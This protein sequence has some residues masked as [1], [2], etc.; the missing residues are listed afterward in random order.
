MVASCRKVTPRFMHRDRWHAR[1]E[2][3]AGDF[4]SCSK[5][6]PGSG[7]VAST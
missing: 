4:G 5:S 6:I 3:R 7:M 1:D 2:R